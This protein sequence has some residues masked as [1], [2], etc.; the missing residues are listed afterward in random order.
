MRKIWNQLSAVLPSFPSRSRL[1]R[2]YWDRSWRVSKSSSHWIFSCKDKRASIKR[3]NS[4]LPS[5]VPH[6]QSGSGVFI[7]QTLHAAEFLD[8]HQILR[9]PHSAFPRAEGASYRTWSTR[10]LGEP[11]SK[12]RLSPLFSRNLHHRDG[13]GFTSLKTSKSRATSSLHAR[14]SV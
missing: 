10:H 7:G 3:S 8:V 5:G 6:C 12:S 11:F 14:A 13:A 4:R 9:P 2:A 1:I